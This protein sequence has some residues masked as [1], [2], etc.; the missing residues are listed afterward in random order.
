MIRAFFGRGRWAVWSYGVGLLVLGLVYIGVRYSVAFN[1]W[2]Q[3]FYD[4]LQ[5]TKHHTLA[6]FYDQIEKFLWLAMPWMVADTARN[7][8]S[9]VYA[10]KWREAITLDYLPR[11]IKVTE[12]IEGA[13]QRIQED[14]FRFSRILEDFGLKAADAVLTLIAFLPVLWGLSRGITLPY[15]G[16]QGSLVWVV[17]LTSLGG[18][19]VAGLVGKRLTGLE[20]ANQRV[21][22]AFRKELV[23]GEDDK[24]IPSLGSLL[25]H[26]VG[27]KYN[28]RRLYA[29]MAYYDVWANLFN[30]GMVVVPYLLAAPGLFSGLLTLGV[31][32]RIGDAFGNVQNS[33]NLLINNWVS[34]TEFRSIW[35]RLTEFEHNLARHEGKVRA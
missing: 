8:L 23:Y 11:W 30:Q 4:L 18:T 3:G 28:Y 35:Q 6:D 16:Q 19:L 17:L 20:Y 7:Y 22:A 15:L 5:D 14:A 25:E 32:I 10:F 12:E 1:Q 31:L 9:R 33:F 21:E 29:N 27:I 2:Y 34:V 26:F 24:T 13:S